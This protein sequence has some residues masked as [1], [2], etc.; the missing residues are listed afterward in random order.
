MWDALVRTHRAVVS[1]YLEKYYAGYF[2]GR[3][4][5]SAIRSK[6]SSQRLPCIYWKCIANGN[7]FNL[8][9]EVK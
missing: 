6:G 7:A 2:V 8:V 5:P 4:Q 9:N 3:F 1:L